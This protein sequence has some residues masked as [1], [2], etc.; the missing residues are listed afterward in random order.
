MDVVADRGNS[1]NSLN[2]ILAEVPGMRSGEAHAAYSRNLADRR[3]QLSKALLPL[4]ISVSVYVLS[5]QLDIGI[6]QV[7]H[8][9]GLGQDRFGC[10]AALF[11]ARV[12]NHA[13][14]AKLVAALDDGDVTAMGI[15][16]GGE[17]GFEGLIGLPVIQSGYAVLPRLDLHQHL[18]KVA[19]RCRSRD[20]GNVRRAFEDLFAFLLGHAAQHRELLPF[21]L[22]LLI[23]LQA[24]K[25][26]LLSLVP[27]GAGVIENETGFFYSLDL[28]VALAHQ[29]SDDFLRI[30]HVHLAPEGLDVESL[31]LR[32]V[33]RNLSH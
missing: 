5:Q 13:V 24:V 33:L 23:I 26:L 31:L 3:Q 14:G 7:G 22:Q 9:P 30:V 32:P 4:R 11:A 29:C 25:N 8:L 2:D 21:R 28:P 10:P 16:A 27:Y 15:A 6:A 1:F 20:Q 18:R 17:F 19:I 12:W